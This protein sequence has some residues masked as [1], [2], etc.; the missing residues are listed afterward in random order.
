MAS[1]AR[2]RAAGRGRL[3][4]TAVVAALGFGLAAIPAAASAAVG[5]PAASAARGAAATGQTAASAAQ[6]TAANPGTTRAALAL[7]AQRARLATKLSGAEAAARKTGGITGTVLGADSQPLAGACVTAVGS[8]VSVTTT[9]SPDGTFVLAG[10]AAGSYALEY[11]DCAA[12]GQYL[13]AWSGGV[14]WR[15]AAALVHVTARQVR[16]VPVVML[17][18]LHPA[19]VLSGTARFRQALAASNRSLTV[20]AVAKTG[21]ISGLVTGK[22]KPLGGICVTAIPVRSGQGYGATTA[23]NGTYSVRYVTPGRY[24]VLFGG[25]GCP[26]GGNWLSQVYPDDNS[27]FAEFGLPGGAAVTVTSGHATRGIDAHL[28]L[29]GQISGTVTGPAGR[30]LGGVCVNVTGNV[31]GGQVGF[32]LATTA[33]GTYQVHALFPGK[34]VVQFVIGC[35]VGGNYAPATHGPVK[36]GYGTDASGVNEKLSP[37]ASV[38]GKVTLGSSAGQPL[39]GMCV[40]ASNADG[41]ISVQAATGPHG[42][43]RVIGLGAG[44]YQLQIS[45]GCNNN[46]NYTTAYLSASTTAGKQTSGV[47]AVL[48]PGATISGTVTDR[49]GRPVPGMCI[50]LDQ[51]AGPNSSSSIGGSATANDGSY[52]VNQL[53]AGTYEIG[54]VTG[55]GDSANYAPYWY[56]NQT[57]EGMATPIV[58]ATGGSQ[59]ANAKLQPGAAIAGTVTDA[60]GHG[61]PGLCVYAATEFEAQL[62]PVFTAEAQTGAHGRY[63]I[64]GLA[65]GQYLIDFGCGVDARYADQWFNGAA[66]ASSADLVSAP[67]GRTAGINAV[68]QPAGSI[69]GVVTNSAGRP[70]AGVCVSAVNAKASSSQLG[71]LIGGNT[72]PTDSHGAY[73]VSGLAAGRYDVLFQPCEGSVRYAEQWYR[74][75]GSTSFQTAV[76]VRMGKGTSGIDARL[77]IGGTISGRVSGAAGKP[78]RNVCVFAFNPVTS[79]SGIG[80]TGRNGTYTI[81]ALPSDTYMIEFLPCGNQNLIP[82]QASAKVTA[83]H[84]V[85]G[86][87]ATLRP[88]GLVSGIVTAAGSGSPIADLCIDIV[89]SDPNNPGGFALTNP[90]GTY[91]AAGLPTGAY[92]VYFG[93]PACPFSG[94]GFIPQWYNNQPTQATANSVS[95]TA[96][97]VTPSID[98]VLQPGASATAGQITGIV[99]SPASAPVAGVCVTAVPISPDL[100]GSPPVVAVSRTGDYRLIGLTPGQYNVEFS[101]GCGASGYQPQWWQD[102]S[103]EAAATPVTVGL[104][105]VV[106]GI[107]AKMSA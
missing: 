34:Y 20:A 74:Q 82:V 107:S 94:G 98:A 52:V 89:S 19:S 54:F 27:P 14:A 61:L 60:S 44:T 21:R 8:S 9:A 7:L 3:A 53:S 62:G 26:S 80:T 59:T 102:A 2:T 32:S 13:P 11:R 10:L 105:Q 12:A 104:G 66:S 42:N 79:Y 85:T 72:P 106:S 38:T 31:P 81:P 49:K 33:K 96:G 68:L 100:A 43:Y 78:L 83:P 47:N 71:G 95:V 58:L 56:D 28:R 16:H 4:V 55:C 17:K 30:K 23:K 18:P 45:P 29:G 93:D 37:G 99:T 46:A 63:T 77:S 50:E 40:F 65:P 73:V 64:S 51:S 22:G 48:L 1:R 67:V 91:Q 88:G 41:S 75:H 101:S 69:S 36:I 84:A 39:A 90:D 25:F 24:F 87:N 5:G 103:S 57:S 70:L 76:Q 97:H 92:Q 86:L 35:G 6:R 15:S